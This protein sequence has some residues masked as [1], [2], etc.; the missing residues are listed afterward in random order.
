MSVDA[1]GKQRTRYGH[2]LRGGALDEI[3]CVGEEPKTWKETTGRGDVTE[4]AVTLALARAGKK[5]LRPVSSAT[6]YDLLVDNEDGTFTR[7]Q[8]KTGRLREGTVE[9]RM[10]SISGHHTRE[11]S[12]RGQIDAFGVYCAETG[13]AYLVP[14]E[15]LTCDTIA[16]LR[17]SPAR[18]GQ[19]RRV[20][21]ASDYLIS[22]RT[23]AKQPAL[24]GLTP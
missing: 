2:N 24:E 14:I 5:I 7:I 1:R 8:C 6:R 22:E 19:M 11:N 16:R 13:D 9:F 23:H 3:T 18:N 12:Y 4:L 20:R 17:I 10:Y 15:A 21:L